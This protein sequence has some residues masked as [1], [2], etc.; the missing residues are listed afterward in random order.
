MH[1]KEIVV[2]INQ[3]PKCCGMQHQR[4]AKLLRFRIERLKDFIVDRMFVRIGRQMNRFEVVHADTTAQLV[5]QR[6]RMPPRHD[7]DRP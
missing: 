5:D 4:N 3:I 6:L 2:A 7:A 1:G